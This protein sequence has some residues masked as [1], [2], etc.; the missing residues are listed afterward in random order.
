M[1]PV[2]IVLGL[3]LGVDVL[4]DDVDGTKVGLVLPTKY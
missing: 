2:E 4:G 3:R 1:I